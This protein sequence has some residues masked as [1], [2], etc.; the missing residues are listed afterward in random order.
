MKT[1]INYHLS[2][3]CVFFCVGVFILFLN[4]TT[5]QNKFKAAAAAKNKINLVDINFIYLIMENFDNPQKEVL[6]LDY[7]IWF[8]FSHFNI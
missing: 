4:Q 3:S 1:K 5:C 2:L 6:Y 8:H 7:I